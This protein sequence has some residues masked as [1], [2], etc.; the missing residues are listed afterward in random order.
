[1]LGQKGRHSASERV[2]RN[3]IAV[4]AILVVAAAYFFIRLLWGRGGDGHSAATIATTA[5]TASSSSSSSSHAAAS[6]AT[7]RHRFAVLTDIHYD[8]GPPD[9][10]K[11]A[12]LQKLRTA[13]TEMAHEGVS[14]L[15]PTS[16]A[17]TA[18]SGSPAPLPERSPFLAV[19]GDAKDENDQARTAAAV[20]QNLADVSSAVRDGWGGDVHWVLG[21]HDVDR[22]FKAEWRE[23]VGGHA[24]GKTYYYA[25][26]VGDTFMGSR[27]PLWVVVLDVGFF[28]D[29]VEW[30][31]LSC[32]EDAEHRGWDFSYVPA[33]EREWLVDTLNAI[34]ASSGVAVVLSHARLDVPQSTRE[35]ALTV[36]NAA[37]VRRILAADGGVTVPL[38]LHGHDHAAGHSPQVE[39]G[40]LY[41]TVPAIVD[42]AR[43]SLPWLAVSVSAAAPCYVSIQGHGVA[44]SIN[45]PFPCTTSSLG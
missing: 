31:C 45:H 5:T 43:G 23:V 36:R 8:G 9:T 13:L 4:L 11:G 39:D 22:L 16:S 6:G 33:S 21:N 15:S 42:A 30:G 10:K 34:R 3:V 2:V 20:K 1:M 25:R 44:P 18:A 40:V 28:S 32:N 35:A 12:A 24:A 26:K 41:Y 29:S 37:E 7:P 19:L 27:R 17:S 14:P 38:V